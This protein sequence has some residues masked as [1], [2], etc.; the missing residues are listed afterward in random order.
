MCNNC[1]KIKKHLKKTKPDHVIQVVKIYDNDSR[2]TLD[3][4]V[5]RDGTQNVLVYGHTNPCAIRTTSCDDWFYD[6][7]MK[8]FLCKA[9]MNS[10][11]TLDDLPTIC[12]KCKNKYNITKYDRMAN[13]IAG[14]DTMA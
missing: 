8:V 12:S 5:H 2:I 11:T 6:P 7:I 1:K 9:C 13:V 3:G 10:H 4:F 14:M